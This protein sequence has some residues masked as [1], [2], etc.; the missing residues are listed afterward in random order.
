VLYGLMTYEEATAHRHLHDGPHSTDKSVAPSARTSSW[1]DHLP[2]WTPERDAHHSGI[3]SRFQYDRDPAKLVTW[4]T[5]S[6]K[7]LDSLRALTVGVA[8]RSR[9]VFACIRNFATVALLLS[10]IVQC[11]EAAFGEAL[12]PFLL[13]TCLKED[14]SLRQ[15]A[16]NAA[17][18]RQLALAE[19]SRPLPSDA[20]PRSRHHAWYCTARG[21]RLGTICLP[22]PTKLIASEQYDVPVI[23]TR[24]PS[25]AKPVLRLAKASWTGRMVETLFP[26]RQGASVSRV[27]NDFAEY[28]ELLSQAEVTLLG[29]GALP[30]GQR[31]VL[32]RIP[33]SSTTSW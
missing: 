17:T 10:A 24:P 33:T 22:A 23:E 3:T 27:N 20:M 12:L 7:Y 19:A 4:R 1:T 8:E 21:R 9:S 26:Y 29:L 11:R 15:S 6:R 2:G 28:I 30:E 32:L 14:S 18:T 13:F 25:P 31:W 5:S 16:S